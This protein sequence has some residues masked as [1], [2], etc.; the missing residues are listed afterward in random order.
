MSLAKPMAFRYIK[1]N[2]TLFLTSSGKTISALTTQT[3]KE[4]INEVYQKSMTEHL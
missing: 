1:K 2:G 3:G 4:P